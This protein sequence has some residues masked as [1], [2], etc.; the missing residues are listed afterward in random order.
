[1]LLSCGASQLDTGCRIS[2][3]IERKIDRT[4]INTQVYKEGKRVYT[5]SIHLMTIE[6]S[7][8]ETHKRL[9]YERAKRVNSLD[10]N[11]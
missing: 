7:S 4:V 5:A 6:V 9:E 1:M 3:N 11:L 8:V 10:C 2:Q